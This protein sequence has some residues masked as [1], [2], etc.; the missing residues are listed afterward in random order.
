MNTIFLSKKREIKGSN[1]KNFHLELLAVAFIPISGSRQGTTCPWVGVGQEPSLL[2][3]PWEWLWG[4]QGLS[5]SRSRLH[6]HFGIPTEHGIKHL[7]NI[8]FFQIQSLDFPNHSW[9]NYP[10]FNFSVYGVHTDSEPS[11]A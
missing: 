8:T 1:R 3:I 10:N 7:Q 6:Q 9:S 4:I 2:F 11:I 5:G